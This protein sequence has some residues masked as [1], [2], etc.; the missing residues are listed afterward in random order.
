MLTKEDGRS[1]YKP[2]RAAIRCFQNYLI[3]NINSVN[4]MEDNY[5]EIPVAPMQADWKKTLKYVTPGEFFPQLCG[6]VSVPF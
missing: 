1:A 6:T 4:H 2:L 3:F 5:D